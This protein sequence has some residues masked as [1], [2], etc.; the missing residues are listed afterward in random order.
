VKRDDLFTFHTSRFTYETMSKLLNALNSQMSIV[1]DEARKCLVQVHNGRR[2]NGAGTILHADG[3]I[4]TNAHVVQRRSPKVTLW[5]GWTLP[6]RLLAY[7]EKRDLA[8]V[9]V[10]A[11]GL[12]TM[13]LGNGNELWPGQWVVALGHPWGVTGATTAGMVIG[14]GRPVEGLPFDGDLIQVGL[15]LRPGH[16]GGPMVDS[17]GR[18]VGINTMIAGPDVGMAVPIQTVKRFLKRALGSRA[19]HF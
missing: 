3:L 5:D 4:V 9:S 1:V 2:G 15:H 7:D 16:S 11:S 6:G 10:D 13:E 14:V 19:G 18:L 8:A 17:N 12:P